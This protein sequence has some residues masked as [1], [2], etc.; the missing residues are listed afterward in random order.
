L[1]FDLKGGEKHLEDWKIK[2][3]VLWLFYTVAFLAVMQLGSLE[4]GVLQHFLDTGEVGGMKIGQEL[5]FL[6]AILILVPLVMAF[7]S[8]TLKDSANRWAN[9]IVGLV[10]TVFQLFALAE[11]LASPSAYAVLIETSKV[12]VPALIVWYSWKSKRQG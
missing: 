3:S 9:V 10:Y 8:L 1:R 6:F 12:V 11:T 5:L 2:I 7:L 4:P